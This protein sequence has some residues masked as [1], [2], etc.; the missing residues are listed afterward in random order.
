[1]YVQVDGV[2]MGS[3]LG[4]LFANFYMGTIEERVFS[5]MPH[6]W[7]YYRYIDDTFVS[8]ED[9]KELNSLR[10][11][12][13]EKSV[14]RFTYENNNNGN[15]PFL[16]VLVKQEQDQYVTTVYTKPTNEDVCLNGK[17]E[18]PTRYLNSVI[19]AYTRRALSHCTTWND[20]H[21]ELDRVS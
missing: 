10:R 15:L 4:V 19:D 11:A 17:S 5:A 6:P 21:K 2:A 8:I 20:T 13:E 16:D 7:L 12:F 9:E 1:M 14:L 18:C 3:P